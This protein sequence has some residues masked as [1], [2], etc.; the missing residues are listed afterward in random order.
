MGKI[1]R[2][3]DVIKLII[4]TRY[5]ILRTNICCITKYLIISKPTT[6]NNAVSMNIKLIEKVNRL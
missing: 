6:Q 5:K 3:N 4:M 1:K 2:E